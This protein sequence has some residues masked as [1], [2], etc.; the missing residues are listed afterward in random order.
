MFLDFALNV[1]AINGAHTP[2]P[3][4]LKPLTQSNINEEPTKCVLAVALFIE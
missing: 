1:L 4:R 2:H 3:T